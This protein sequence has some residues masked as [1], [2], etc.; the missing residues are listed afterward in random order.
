MDISQNIL[1]FSQQLQW[2]WKFPWNLPGGSWLVPECFGD[3]R[4]LDGLYSRWREWEEWKG[5]QML[6]KGLCSRKFFCHTKLAKILYFPL[7]FRNFISLCLIYFSFPVVSRMVSIEWTP[8]FERTICISAFQKG[9]S[10]KLLS[11]LLK[12]TNFWIWKKLLEPIS[13]TTFCKTIHKIFM[14]TTFNLTLL[15]KIVRLFPSQ[16]LK[17]VFPL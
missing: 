17:Q 13:F 1:L 15:G 8:F 12:Q 5:I 2:K 7:K 3:D 9:R 11:F 4:K 14:D 10:R 16:H 6:R